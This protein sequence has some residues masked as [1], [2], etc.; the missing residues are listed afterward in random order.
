NLQRLA[1]GGYKWR[2]NLTAIVTSYLKIAGFP[3]PN[4]VFSNQTLFIHGE[5]SP[6][7][8]PSDHSLIKS[9]FTDSDIQTIFNTAHL[10]HI[11]QPDE[12][13]HRIKIF[14]S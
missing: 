6:Y 1:K 14:L 10:P 13:Y 4:L 3:L 7:I 12:F 8:K 2:C 9:L 11:E 5:N